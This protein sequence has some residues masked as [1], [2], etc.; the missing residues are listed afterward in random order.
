[1]EPLSEGRVVRVLVWQKGGYEQRKAEAVR[2][3]S[4]NTANLTI[5][6][7]GSNDVGVTLPGGAPA[8]AGGLHAHVER[9]E[10]V[11]SL[12][13]AVALGPGALVCFWPPRAL[14]AVPA[15]RGEPPGRHLDGPKR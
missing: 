7:D 3:W 6:L 4:E 1:M 13:A 14:A 5:S 8:V 2:V 12:D 9:V 10:L 15:K 11:E